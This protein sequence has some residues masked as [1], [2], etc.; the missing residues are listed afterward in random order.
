MRWK[1]IFRG[2]RIQEFRDYNQKPSPKSLYC[3]SA[4]QVG[5]SPPESAVQARATEPSR[6]APQT[7]GATVQRS[8]SSSGERHS[9]AKQPGKTVSKQVEDEYNQ[10]KTRRGTNLRRSGFAGST[11]VVSKVQGRKQAQAKENSTYQCWV[12]PEYPSTGFFKAATRFKAC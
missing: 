2:E 11:S 5:L 1:I 12:P 8:N 7:T 4:P 6:G 3:V 10:A 9:Q